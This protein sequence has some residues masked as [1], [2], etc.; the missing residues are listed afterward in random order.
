MS[1]RN[2]ETDGFVIVLAFLG[3]G[4]ILMGYVLFAVATLLT[5]VFTLIAFVAWFRPLT[6]FGETL[7]PQEARWFVYR[8]LIGM[9]G[10]PAFALFCQALFQLHLNDKLWSVFILAG[11]MG[12]SLGIEILKAIVEEKKQTLAAEILPP[13]APVNEPAP[14]PA[15]REAEPFQ[16]ASWDDEEEF[17]K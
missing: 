9:I 15:P 14:T 10:L 4:I 1:G 8:G 12:G 6:L 2:S 16:Y 11:Y 5:I 3:A 17:G 7:T 13:S